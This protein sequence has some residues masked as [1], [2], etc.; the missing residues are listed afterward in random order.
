[1]RKGTLAVVLAAGSAT[2]AGGPKAIWPVSKVPSVAKVARAAL[3]ASSVAH[4]IVV[5]G[6]WRREV[7]EALADLG[8][9]IELVHNPRFELGLSTSLKAALE[10]AGGAFK[11]AVFLQ[12]DQPLVTPVLIDE[13]A[14]ALESSGAGAAA[15]VAGGR[16]R[17][18]AVFSLERFGPA[19]LKLDG[20]NGGREVLRS[21]PE[22]LI[23]VAADHHDPLIFEDFDTLSEYERLTSLSL[24]ESPRPGRAGEPDMIPEPGR[25]GRPRPI[26]SGPPSPP[27]ERKRR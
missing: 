6:A 13:L 16:R 25:G 15:P 4:V 11:S 12:A 26:A 18:P 19:L 22:D 27:S 21:R 3:S 2:R 8:S 20:D 17:S 23:L 9:E 5:T 7:E 24:S 1:M 14:A 10:A